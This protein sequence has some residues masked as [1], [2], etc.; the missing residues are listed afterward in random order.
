MHDLGP[1]IAY[2]QERPREAPPLVPPNEGSALDL[3]VPRPSPTPRRTSPPLTQNFD[4]H[5][6]Q[7]VIIFLQDTTW[8]CNVLSKCWSCGCHA[9]QWQSCRRYCFECMFRGPYIL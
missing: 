1:K 7:L 9:R 8:F 5:L 4:P 3:A 6:T 2:L